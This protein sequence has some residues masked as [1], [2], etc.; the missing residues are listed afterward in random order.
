MKNISYYV[1]VGN[2]SKA[3]LGE[4]ISA[5]INEEMDSEPLKLKILDAIS[6]TE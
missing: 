6:A 5:V 1:T 4:I 2:I 3:Q